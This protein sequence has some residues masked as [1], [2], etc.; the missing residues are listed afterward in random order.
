[1]TPSALEARTHNGAPGGGARPVARGLSPVLL[2]AAGLACLAAAARAALDV[3]DRGPVLDAGAFTMRVTNAGILGNA[4]FD[5]GRSFDPSLEFPRGSGHELLG[6][7]ELWVGAVPARGPVRVSGGPMLEWRPTLDPNDRVRGARAGQAGSLWHFDDDHDGRIDEDPV[8]GRDDDGDGRVDEDFGMVADQQYAADY[9]DDEPASVNYAYATGESHV[10]LHLSVHEESFAWA[11]PGYDHVAGFQFT[12]TNMGD[13]PL[14]DLQL[15]VYADLDA[16]E[17]TDASGHVNDVVELM[18][19]QLAVPEG[20]SVVNAGGAFTKACFTRIEGVA[21]VVHDG[22]PASGLPAVALVPLSHTTDPLGYLVNYAFPGAR[23][24]QAS[25]R[26]PRRDTTFRYSVFSQGL[27]PEQG[28]PPILDADR[29]RA[30]EG[31]YPQSPL[32][33]AQ[34]WA[35]LLSCGPFARLEPRQSVQFAVAFVVAPSRDSMASYVTLPGLAWRGTRYNFQPDRPSKGPSQFSVGETGTNGHEICYEPPPGVVFNYDPHCPPKFYTD[36][37]PAVPTAEHYPFASESTYV[38]GKCIWSDFDCDACTGLDGKETQIHWQV[39]G[40][41]P[42]KPTLRVVAG[43]TVATLLWDNLPEI[44]LRQPGGWSLG[45]QFGGY[46]IYRVDDWRRESLLPSPERWQQIAQFRPPELAFAGP[47]LGPLVDPGVPSDT[48]AYGMP[49]YPPGHY[50]FVDHALLDGFDYLYVVTTVFSRLTF[51]NG[52]PILDEL[53]SPLT[54]AFDEHVTP[55]VAAAVNNSRVWVVPNPYRENAAWERSPV[56]GDPFT[57]H[58]DFFGLPRARSTI[59]IYT[60]AG[61]LVRV[62]DHDGSSGDG[63]APWNLIS[64]NGQDIESGIYLFTVDSTAGHQV[65]KFVVIR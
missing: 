49:H 31:D 28:G 50:R 10:P 36:Y 2:L 21:P 11:L 30:L 29:Y 51:S 56:P 18:P 24:A 58:V 37:L 48:V 60:L 9:R 62:L 25:A 39:G 15:G 19:Y 61:D 63:Q 64:R 35:V 8:N 43:D 27:P 46:R 33:G 22:R 32:T 23:E 4:F 26:A 47:P 20:I 40:L 13:A 38:A 53:E 34:D 45:Y 6:H 14:H 12:I 57:R 1:M 59:R 42:P 52:A 55:Q 7:A 54:S 16:R 41:L 44:M 5:Q 65:G 3:D 17:R